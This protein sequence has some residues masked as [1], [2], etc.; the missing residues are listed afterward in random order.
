MRQ[1]SV[2]IAGLTLTFS[3]C[4]RPPSGLYASPDVDELRLELDDLRHS[5]HTTQVELHLLEEQLLKHNASAAK[6]DS[7]E[8]N[9]IGLPGTQLS[10]L[11]KKVSHLEKGLE[12]ACDDLRRL[13]QSLTQSLTKIQTFESDLAAHDRRLEE[14][15]K[16]KSTLTSI[17]K[18]IGGRPSQESLSVATKSY[19]VKAGD[20]L[21][22]IARFHH[23]SVESLRKIN[24]LSNDKIVVGQ[25]LRIPDD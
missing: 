9:S 6:N 23:V 14:V 17:S 12:K 3:L 11:E 1:F 24:H 2:F 18:A 20:S 7:R 15:T 25:E 10:S 5:L 4:A 8:A 13:S 16:L 21:E 22:K 19:R